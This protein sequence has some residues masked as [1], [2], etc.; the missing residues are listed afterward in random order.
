MN[1]IL[2]LQQQMMD[3]AAHAGD[4]ANFW[5]MALAVG[6]WSFLIFVG[7]LLYRIVRQ[8]ERRNDIRERELCR[9]EA[10]SDV[11]RI[12]RR[13]PKFGTGQLGTRSDGEYMPKAG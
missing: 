4:W 13:L 5:I 2:A 6:N 9:K 1:D 10:D 8:V 11:E 3:R 7:C 12:A